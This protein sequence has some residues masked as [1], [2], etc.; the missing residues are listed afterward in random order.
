V[1]STTRERLERF[2]IAVL[3]DVRQCAENL[4]AF[5][6]EF[7]GKSARLKQFLFD[8]MYRH[9]RLIRMEE[10]ARMIIERLFAAYMRNTD[11]IAPDF[12][13]R[14]AGED[15]VILVADYI[16]GMTDRFAMLEFKKLF[17]P[18]ERV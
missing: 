7:A 16:A 3:E 2:G 4:A 9:Y 10:K 6:P 15:K 14:L 12:R 5:S 18:F 11:Q 13:R 8:N 17:D 1:V